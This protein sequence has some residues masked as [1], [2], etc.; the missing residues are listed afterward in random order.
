MITNEVLE[1]LKKGEHKAFE[2]AFMSYFDKVKRFIAG[3]I[4]SDEDAEDLAQDVFAKI[5]TERDALDTNLSFQ[6]FLYTMARNAAFNYL[7]RQSVR[8]TYA[9]EYVQP[10]ETD[11]PE[12]AVFA[13]EIE[14]L[15]E[16]ALRR[17]PEKRSR[18]YRLSRQQGLSNDE[19]AKRLTISKKT[20][21]NNLSMAL[22]EIR[23]IISLAVMLFI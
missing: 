4:R 9:N 22:N 14:L 20:V 16:M 18:I 11:T 7:K 10:E 8:T 5:W 12:E 6:S 13:K 21:E 1:D 3:L 15:I 23:K 17:M 19:I 2:A